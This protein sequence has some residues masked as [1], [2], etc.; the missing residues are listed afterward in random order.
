MSLWV[1]IQ[2][3]TASTRLPGKVLKCVGGIPLIRYLVDTARGLTPNV[4]VLIPVG[5]EK[6]KVYCRDNN[7]PCFEGSE[8]DLI[9]R[10]LSFAK[11][12]GASHVVR[13]TADCPFLDI[14]ELSYMISTCS[15]VNADI[16]TNALAGMRTI[17]DGNDVEVFSTR[18][19]Q[20]LNEK[21]TEDVD[22]EHVGS[23]AYRNW[24]DICEERDERGRT[25]WV[26]LIRQS[27]WPHYA[28]PRSKTS[29]D[30][31]EEYIA[32]CKIVAGQ[33]GQDDTVAKKG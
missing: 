13:L 33:G 20:Y 28:A 29:I 24:Q 18:F 19:L 12:Y 11:T 22:R 10:Y 25:K 6:L 27:I 15:Q 17:I 32:A 16:G 26:T 31:E 4:V 3:R 2:A 9:R 23:Y 14:A 21:V 8:N 7:I 5:D 30:T 1:G